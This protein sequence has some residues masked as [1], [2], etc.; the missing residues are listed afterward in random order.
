MARG[1]F[2]TFE[3]GE[4]AGKSTQVKRLANRLERAGRT[5]VQTR[6][7]GGSPSAEEIRN[8][9]VTGRA[10]RWSPLAETLLFY[11]ARVEHW[12]QVI[13][14]ALASG[15]DVICDR[16][17]DSTMAYQ[18]Y[19]GGLPRADIERLHSLVVPTAKPDITIILD[20]PPDVGLSRAAHRHGNENRF[21]SKDIGFHERLRQG[22]IDIA[23][24]EPA[25]CEVLD[26]NRSIDEID[27]TVWS[28]I[29][30]RLNIG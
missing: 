18:A 14:P 16:F 19:A 17:A 13:D 24:R 25:R 20:L 21:E 9:L 23:K 5:V 4:G 26:A 15:K 28:V 1:A 7:P 22:F 29:R 11:A 12:R 10:D 2:I 6:E 27:E 30:K 3:G 8:L